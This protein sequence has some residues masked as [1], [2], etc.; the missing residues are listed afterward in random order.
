MELSVSTPRRLKS[1]KDVAERYILL[2]HMCRS[3]QLGPRSCSLAPSCLGGWGG[4]W[5]KVKL[6]A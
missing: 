4:E 6:V 3:R 1:L 5:E 2:L